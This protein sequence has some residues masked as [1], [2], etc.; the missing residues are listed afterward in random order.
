[1]TERATALLRRFQASSLAFLL[2]ACSPPPLSPS[3]S[4]P[5]ESTAPQPSATPSASAHEPA[6][7]PPEPLPDGCA[8]AVPAGLA[9]VARLGVLAEA[10][11][12]GMRPLVPAPRVATL[13]AGGTLALPFSVADASRC[14]R[15]GAT[16]SAG[17]RQ[18][19]L[20]LV[21]SADRVIAADRLLGGVAL[22]NREGPICVESAGEYRAVARAVQGNGEVALQ[23][24]QAE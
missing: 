16:S 12:R 23:V 18:L 24:W 22:A 17:M 14:L 5:S 8:T 3:P 4:K 11:A 6:P 1:M 19:E 7:L 9:P 21:D 13:S 20:E 10:C 15:A 2:G